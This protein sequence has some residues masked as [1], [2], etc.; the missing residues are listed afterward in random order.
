[1]TSKEDS[2]IYFEYFQLTKEYK[3]KYGTNTIVLLQVGAFFEVYALKHMEKGDIF[4]SEIVAFSQICNLNVS[5]KKAT[6]NEHQV[7]M[8]GFRDYTLEKYL[9]K[10]TENHFTA[11]VYVQEKTDKTTRRVF[12]SVYSA[13]TYISYENDSSPQMT[14]NIM[15]IWLDTFRSL[16]T[17]GKENLIY[18]VSVINILT[19]NSSIFEH[20]TPFLMNPTTFDELE[21]ALCTF[22]PS[23]VI[24]LSSFDAPTLQTIIQFSGIKTPIVHIVNINDPT[25]EKAQKCQ[26]QKYMQHILSSFYGEETFQMCLE[27]NTHIMA[28]QSFCYLLNF[29]Q[30]YNPHLVRKIALP[31][32]NNTS[33]RMLL[34]NHTL[35]QLNIIDDQTS[36]GKKI[37]QLSSVLAFLN[38]C[39]SPMGRRRFQLQ[40]VNPTFNEEWL[41]TEYSMIDALLIGSA[42]TSSV[43]SI[44]NIR[45]TISQIRDIEKIG[46][47]LVLQK[48]YPSSI[49]HLYKSIEH[50]RNINDSV[51][52]SSREMHRYL[53]NDFSVSNS[54]K[55]EIDVIDSTCRE[56]LLL[57]DSQLFIEKCATISSIH[58]YSELFIKPEVSAVLDEYIQKQKENTSLFYL[59]REHF[60]LLFISTQGNSDIQYIKEHETEKS[61]LSLQIT[62][63]RGNILKKLLAGSP[64][65]FLKINENVVIPIK[66]IQF[67]HASASNDEIDFPLLSKITRDILLMKDKINEQMT[68]VYLSFI[69]TLEQKGLT[70]LENLSSYISK[71]DVL[72]S[73]A[74]VAQEYNYCKPTIVNDAK[75]SFVDAHSL[76]HVLIEH[77]QQNEIYVS[78]DLGI[79]Q[80]QGQGQRTSDGILLYGTNAVGK[81][82][83]IRALGISVVMA[84]CGMYVPCSQFSFKPYTALFSRILGNDNIFKGLSTF[85][86]EMSELRIILKLADQNSLVLG[87][88]LCSGTETE[89]ALSIFMAGLMDLHKK[90]SSFIFATHFHEIVHY[91]EITSLERL[92]MKHLSVYYDRELD[93]LVYDRKIKDGSGTRMYGLEVCKSLHLPDEFLEKAYQLR[94]KYYPDTKGELG[95][96]TST[97]NAKKIRGICEM[98]KMHIGEEVHHLQPQKEAN[99]NGFIDSF[100]KNHPANLMNICE[101]CHNKIHSTE[102]SSL[103]SVVEKEKEKLKKVVIRKKTTKGYKVMES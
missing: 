65:P 6:F 12:N 41:K 34:V 31:A 43:L 102:M 3:I 26:T 99:A 76:R 17:P 27:F 2:S 84:Q 68:V 73:K 83:I 45:K 19:G 36:D 93:C 24:L 33:D 15:C 9:Q 16:Q 25:A 47:N 48:I 63:T 103:G 39:C 5:E 77:I 90:E 20:Q 50:I 30:E 100:H 35:K 91:D 98:C 87:D 1:M 57:I 74:Y 62:K 49:Y 54:M 67:K 46:R 51:Y 21:R 18:G 72:Q 75:K 60:N 70:H 101:T 40:M 58:S 81:T 37:G 8:A 55:L 92:S 71:L 82:S 38:R 11:V 14:N 88:E 66:D 95:F 96:Q 10:L 44:S 56:L 7:L 64:T 69:Q 13:G 85:A 28:T 4:E 78:N 23:E 52:Q 22:S 59:I 89:S 42:S 53:C 32:F 29:I 79:G 97:Y 94:N 86:V 61:G 80:G